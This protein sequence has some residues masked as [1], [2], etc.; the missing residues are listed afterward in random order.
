MRKHSKSQAEAVR[1]GKE[2]ILANPSVGVDLRLQN[3]DI[4][5]VAVFFGVVQAVAHDEGVGH[6]EADIV[7]VDGLDAAL[8]LVQQGAQ[9]DGGGSSG[10]CRSPECPPPR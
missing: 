8:R 4:G 7:G 9:L 5:Q 6:G 2:T 1:N 3:A 10:C